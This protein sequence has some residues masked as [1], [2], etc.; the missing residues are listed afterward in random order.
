M[1]Y[2]TPTMRL[3]WRTSMADP[4]TARS[5][6]PLWV[7]TAFLGVAE[8]TV[9]VVATQSA[10]WLQGLLAIFSVSFPVVIALAFF[11]ILW[12]RPY[13][14]YSP[15]DYPEG[16]KVAE[17]VNA[18]AVPPKSS[19]RSLDTVLRSTLEA[20]LDAGQSTSA[21]DDAVERAVEKAL[22]MAHDQVDRAMVIIDT[23]RLLVGDAGAALA[24]QIG[25]PVFDGTTVQEF[26]DE[27]WHSLAGAVPPY[28]YGT[29]WVLTDTR[30]GEIFR[31][32][33][34]LWAEEHE[35]ENGDSRPLSQ[36]GIKQGDRL[37][38]ELI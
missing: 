2:L 6:N 34:S 25:I 8:V 10:G 3:T 32:M 13:V 12:F 5:M 4:G 7:I 30:S 33:G 38:I 14:L 23:R 18:V 26:L 36:V 1:H 24:P 22:A 21:N 35:R 20:T 11:L 19:L 15:Q 37:A 31:R 16:T 27:L 29:R 28:T 17:F 9:G